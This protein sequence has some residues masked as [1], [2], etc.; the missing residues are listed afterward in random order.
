[1]STQLLFYQDAVPVSKEE[2]ANCSIDTT[3]DFSFARGVNSVPLTATEFPFAARDYPIVFAGKD[4]PMPAVIVG[5]DPGQNLFVT[6]DGHWSDCYIPAFVRRYPFVLSSDPDNTSFTLYIDKACE[7][8]NEVGRGERLFDD[9][10]ANTAYL[11]KMLGFLQEYQKQF[12][13]TRAFC[14]KLVELDLLESMRAQVSV[15]GGDQQSLTGF[16]VIN[17]E[18]LKALPGDTLAELAR[19][20]VLEL[21]YLHRQSLNNFAVMAQRATAKI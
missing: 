18:K 10:G 9:D 6:D 12:R 8:L 19:T 14:K 21:A 20:D 5:V 13:R 17:R 7:S 1:M 11:D 4:V 3:H 2:H 16:E 15:P